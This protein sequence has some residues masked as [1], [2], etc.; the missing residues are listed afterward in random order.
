MEVITRNRTLKVWTMPGGEICVPGYDP[1]IEAPNL[2]GSFD[3]IPVE[4][5]S[6][7]QNYWSRRC[8]FLCQVVEL[9]GAAGLLM[10]RALYFPIEEGKQVME[11]YKKTVR[12]LSPAIEAD[13]SYDAVDA[14]DCRHFFV[15]AFVW[16]D[17]QPEVF[18]QAMYRTHI[19]GN[20]GWERTV[21][22]E[23]F[24]NALRD[25]KSITP[26]WRFSNVK[27]VIDTDGT[28]RADAEEM[29]E[30]ALRVYWDYWTCDRGEEAD[31]K[32][33][34]PMVLGGTDYNAKVVVADNISGLLMTKVIQVDPDQAA[35]DIVSNFRFNA[36]TI[37]SRIRVWTDITRPGETEFILAEVFIPCYEEEA[38]F[39]SC[40]YY[41]HILGRLEQADA[42]T[43]NEFQRILDNMRHSR[44][45]REISSKKVYDIT[46]SLVGHAKIEADSLDEALEIAGEF[47]REDVEW[48]DDFSATDVEEV[49]D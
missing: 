33:D 43:F 14:G 9:D 2:N 48:A 25:E 6:V 38:V 44:R 5:R 42:P 40:M 16:H 8:S 27:V 32:D 10:E 3:D 29:P 11:E 21:T 28:C 34:V 18:Y 35:P 13:T 15:Q 46:F 4:F 45:T 31:Q 26:Q 23:N 20:A 22:Y 7:Y 36:R 47:S 1:R 12:N 37:S 41:M 49:S 19:L 30:E 24:V 17:N 39:R